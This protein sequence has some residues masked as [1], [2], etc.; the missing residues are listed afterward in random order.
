LGGL[1]GWFKKLGESVMECLDDYITLRKF[2]SDSDILSD[3]FEAA[4]KNQIKFCI[5]SNKEDYF[6]LLKPHHITLI[7]SS[8]PEK[9]DVSFEV[10]KNTTNYQTHTQSVNYCDLWINKNKIDE[11]IQ[12][13]LSL[14]TIHPSAIANEKSTMLKLIL[15]MAI[16]SYHYNPASS[17]N[18][19]T[20]NNKGSIKH[21]LSRFG[22]TVDEETIRKYLEEASDK[23]Q[24]VLMKDGQKMLLGKFVI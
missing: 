15:G 22:L 11:I 10:N 13:P 21:D 7:Q 1:F 16:A 12:S 4:I 24:H 20:G 8:H 14:P 3:L 17:R 2:K 18:S 9:V 6:I 23:Y 5:Q 19:A